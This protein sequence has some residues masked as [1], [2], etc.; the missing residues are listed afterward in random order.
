MDVPAFSVAPGEMVGL[1]G[2]SGSGKS[3]LLRHLAG[4]V[5]AD[6]GADA[7]LV[8]VLGRDVQY[9]GRLAPGVRQVRARV[10]VVFQ[11]FNLVGRLPVV[12]NV[13]AGSLSRLPLWRT[14]LGLFP[15]EE[16]WR[17]FAALDRVGILPTAYQRAS[18]L[19]GGQQQRAAIARALVQGASVVLAD[20]P[21]ASLDPES[22]RQVLDALAELN[23]DGTTVLV[24]LH[25]VELARRYCRRVVGLRA[26]RIVFD[27][28]P[29]S[30]TDAVLAGIYGAAVPAVAAA[31]PMPLPAPDLVPARA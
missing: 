19:S 27:G 26:G 11:Q 20:E 31:A 29:G 21:V 8:R 10:G 17:A 15:R 16:T 14:L 22:A 23:G 6:R 2:A 13:L 9:G 3:T 28:P 30:L 24:S 4:L 12:T 7:G 25:Q 1:V 18:T 5:L